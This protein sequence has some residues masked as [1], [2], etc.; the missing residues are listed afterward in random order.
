MLHAT[1]MPISAEQ[2]AQLS[3]RLY[4]YARPIM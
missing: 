1:T 2:A 3:G 4:L